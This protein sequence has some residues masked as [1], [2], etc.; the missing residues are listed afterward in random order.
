MEMKLYFLNIVENRLKYHSSSLLINQNLDTF[1]SAI[2]FPQ[3]TVNENIIG[4]PIMQNNFSAIEIFNF[5]I[6]NSN[7]GLFCTAS[8]KVITLNLLCFIFG[9]ISLLLFI[10]SFSIVIKFILTDLF[11]IKKERRLHV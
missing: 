9:I 11:D 6:C 5:P 8:Y 3:G 10:I 7:I 4:A 1:P 2:Q